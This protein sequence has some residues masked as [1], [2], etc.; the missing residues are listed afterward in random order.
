MLYEGSGAFDKKTDQC[1][2]RCEAME[3]HADVWFPLV[4]VETL[5]FPSAT[6]LVA[7]VPHCKGLHP[8]L[9]GVEHIA[10]CCTPCTAAPPRFNTLKK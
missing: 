10:Q 2:Q 6:Q 8:L 5:G 1:C 3:V 4:A 9:P 7:A